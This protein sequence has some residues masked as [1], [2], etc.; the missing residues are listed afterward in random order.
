[1][2]TLCFKKEFMVKYKWL[3][4]KQIAAQRKIDDILKVDELYPPRHRE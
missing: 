3:I 4:P 2:S 1:M